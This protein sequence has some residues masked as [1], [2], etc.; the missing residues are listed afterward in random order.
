MLRDRSRRILIPS[1]WARSEGFAEERMCKIWPDGKKGWSNKS[2]AHFSCSV[3]ERNSQLSAGHCCFHTNLCEML[4]GGG[5]LIKPTKLSKNPSK[6]SC[7]SSC[8]SRPCSLAGKAWHEWSYPPVSSHLLTPCNRLHSSPVWGS[9]SDLRT[10]KVV[11]S[12]GPLHL[13]CSLP[14][15][16]L[17]S[18]WHGRFL[19]AFEISA[20]MRIFF[21]T[22]SLSIPSAYFYYMCCPYHYVV[23][24]L[25]IFSALPS[26]SARW[27]QDF[28][29]F[30]DAPP[31]PRTVQLVNYVLN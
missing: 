3:G 2:E 31:V 25:L 29:L 22:E 20:S 28:V 26:R 23:F 19:A 16:L 8:N 13:L 30:V 1:R 9:L 21:T 14:R 5:R 7:F 12:T 4:G 6:L 17:S 27:V 24:F 11:S 15:M 18:P 10:W